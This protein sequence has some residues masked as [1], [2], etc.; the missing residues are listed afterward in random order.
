[1]SLRRLR[2]LLSLAHDAGTVRAFIGHRLRGASARRLLWRYRSLARERGGP[3]IAAVASRRTVASLRGAFDVVPLWPHDAAAVADA[4]APDVLLVES[5]AALPGQAWVAL[6]TA[7]EPG[8][9]EA[10]L[11]VVRGLQARSVPVVFWWTA[12][13]GETPRLAEVAGR[14]DV[15]AS[16]DSVRGA[17]DATPLSDGVD[18]AGLGP[19]ERWRVA[20]GPP[21]LHL[22]GCEPDPRRG[23]AGRLL[24]AALA[25]GAEV[26]HEPGH[27]HGVGEILRAEDAACRYRRAAWT[28]PT[29]SG[30][31]H[32]C[33]GMLANGVPVLTTAAPAAFREVLTVVPAHADAVEAAAAARARLAVPAVMAR[34]LRT[35]DAAGTTRARLSAFLTRCGVSPAAPPAGGIGVRIAPGGDLDAAL[36]AI[37]RQTMPPAEILAEGAAARRLAATTRPLGIPVRAPERAASPRHGVWRGGAWPDTFLHDLLVASRMLGTDRISVD[38]EA[39]MDGGSGRLAPLPWWLDGNG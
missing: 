3:L 29:S 33:I 24:A 2:R 19:P 11:G 10:L 38:G 28:T 26:L 4:I 39:V 16:D 1:M 23:P 18:L 13:A 36:A 34:A 35:I 6:A 17:P 31:S 20:L 30:L 27:R 21:L 22:G 5:A 37:G 9:R 14:C 7:A 32:R 12:P 25:A 15:V 8:V